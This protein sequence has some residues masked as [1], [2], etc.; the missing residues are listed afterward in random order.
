MKEAGGLVAEVEVIGVTDD[1]TGNTGF[2][3][4][5]IE[6]H[7]SVPRW[8]ARRVKVKADLLDVAIIVGQVYAHAFQA[9]VVGADAGCKAFGTRVLGD[10]RERVVNFAPRAIIRST[11][12]RNE[13]IGVVVE[14]LSMLHAVVEVVSNSGDR[15]AL[16][17]LRCD[18]RDYVWFSVWTQPGFVQ[19]FR[20][21]DLIV[22]VHVV[23][24]NEIGR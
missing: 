22:L 15:R 14:D 8:I 24:S 1:V 4:T 17:S 11:C 13:S 7:P 16:R 19:V 23:C 10:L 6:G 12:C 21:D 5:S 18:V 20:F 2:R 9:S 3:I